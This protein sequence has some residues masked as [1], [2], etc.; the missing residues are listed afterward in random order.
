MDEVQRANM[1]KFPRCENCGGCGQTMP[2]D[3]FGA[4]RC[5]TC[6]VVGRVVLRDASGK[7]IKP[8]G[9]TPPDIAAVLKRQRGG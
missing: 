4:E 5:D 9:W 7:V 1:S 2:S 3:G 8:P 6:N